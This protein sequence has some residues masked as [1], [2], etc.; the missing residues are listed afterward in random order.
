M[1]HIVKCVICTGFEND[2]EWREERKKGEIPFA[3]AFLG[4]KKGGKEVGRGEEKKEEKG[5]K[6][7]KKGIR[8]VLPLIP[9]LQEGKEDCKGAVEEFGFFGYKGVSE[10]GGWRRFR[11]LA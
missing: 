3:P 6:A 8:R 11:F 1:Y 4:K 9:Y 5:K 7:D 10:E 2:G